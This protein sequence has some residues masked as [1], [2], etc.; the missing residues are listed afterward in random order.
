MN[1]I[2]IFLGLVFLCSGCV[3]TAELTT[4]RHELTVREIVSVYPADT[5]NL[6][7]LLNRTLLERETSGLYAVCMLLEDSSDVVRIRAEYALSGIVLNA[8]PDQFHLI[9]QAILQALK[10]PLATEKKRFLLEQLRIC[11]S[12]LSLDILSGLLN[13]ALLSESALQ[14]LQSIG[15]PRSADLMLN[16]ISLVDNDLKI[17]ILNRLGDL[18][19]RIAAPDIFVMA[20]NGPEQ[21][22]A[23]ALNA[24]ANLG[25]VQADD[26][27]YHNYQ[28]SSVMSKSRAASAYVRFLENID[29]DDMRISRCRKIMVDQHW[30]V[31]SRLHAIQ[32]LLGTVESSAIPEIYN[33][34]RYGD[35]RLKAGGFRLLIPWNDQTQKAFWLNTLNTA[36]PSERAD[37]IRFLGWQGQTA[38]IRYIIPFL[39]DR[40]ETVRVAAIQA[41]V[42]IDPAAAAAP[43]FA[44]LKK[45]IMDSEREELIEAFLRLPGPQLEKELPG[46][47]DE[48]QKDVRIFVSRLIEVRE[49]TSMN[50]RLVESLAIK[51]KDLQLAV[52]HALSFTG[53][54]QAFESILAFGLH[55]TD[56][57]LKRTAGKT[58]VAIISRDDS[59]QILESRLIRGFEMENRGNKIWLMDLMRYV[60]SPVV[61]AYL[62]KSI[63]EPSFSLRE[64]A[65]RA[66]TE[67]QTPIAIGT[68][69]GLA[70]T[71]PQQHQ[72]ILAFRGAIRLI[73]LSDADTSFLLRNH[74]ELLAIAERAAEKRLVIGAISDIPGIQTIQLLMPYLND[75]EV[76]NEAMAAVYKI[77]SLDDQ[78]SGETYELLSVLMP[79]LF[80]V[81]R[82]RRSEQESV[83]I[84]FRSLFN[85]T[86]LEGWRGQLAEPPEGV[87]QMESE[88][89]RRQMIADS[90]MEAHWTVRDGVIY[91]DGAGENICSVQEYRNFE[92]LVDWK[93][94]PGSDSGIYLRG[95][96]QV[97]IWDIRDHPEG[98]GGLF[99]N[100][101]SLNKPLIAA[102]KPA[103]EWN[104]FRISLVN[105]RVNVW[106]NDHLVVDNLPMEN[107]WE[108]GTPLYSTGPL[109]LQA[110]GSPVY[111]KNIYICE[112]SETGGGNSVLLF[113]EKDLTGWQVV[114]GQPE[115][116]LVNDRVLAA[117][118]DGKGWLSSTR[119]YADFDLN[120][121]FRV[122]PGGNSGIFLRAPLTGDPAYTGMEIQILDDYAVHYAD[123][124]P[125]QYTGSLYDL[126]A[127]EI[128]VSKSAGEW[129]KMRIRCSGPH[130]QVELN[131]RIIN[132]VNLIDFMHREPQ[133]PGIKR[134]KGFIGLQ[135]HGLSVEF[136]NIIITELFAKEI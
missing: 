44:Y 123:L 43:L 13:D 50:T 72:R 127:P 66:V 103:G 84:G 26:L 131:G 46:L 113:N 101:N 2:L 116:W 51:D 81:G 62:M 48:G 100:K 14:T 133:H 111:F 36:S 115:H 68:L 75:P 61:I 53:K 19:Y 95:V 97:Q 76:G 34:I 135:N 52:L 15:T 126:S 49:M 23:A 134:R 96:P 136:R 29:D 128:R 47:W 32:I 93:I 33:L 6:Q 30:P 86:D 31:N 90:I 39:D 77:L 10:S 109:E 74:K 79:D 16:K 60:P 18:D 8:F 37:I 73:R 83:P 122:S 88:K 22:R 132:D 94:E 56:Q 119:E 108:P 114:D 28:D 124:K 121:E 87:K 67:W 11:G 58:L 41:L 105:E 102:D 35:S 80:L 130:L 65:F 71:E 24:L 57:E 112:L 125:W 99:N 91:F 69:I 110:H 1:R 107:Y 120:L 104:R 38:W 5:S 7:N 92:L 17:S 78:V 3:S 98:S 129:Q 55:E 42:S 59:S 64:E 70:K 54:I 4:R 117:V 9:E 40:D 63:H 106:L 45:N 20:V 118:P 21:V 25:Y 82:E 89:F 12:N 27:L 85:G